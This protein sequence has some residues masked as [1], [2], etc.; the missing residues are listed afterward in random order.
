MECL[1]DGEASFWNPPI[2]YLDLP[3]EDGKEWNSVVTLFS[4]LDRGG[5]G[6]PEHHR[7]SVDAA[8]GTKTPAGTF[9]C[10]HLDDVPLLGESLGGDWYSPGIGL[11]KMDFGSTSQLELLA[12]SQDGWESLPGIGEVV[13]LNFGWE[14]GLSMLVEKRGYSERTSGERADTTAVS[15]NYRIEVGRLPSGMLIHTTDFDFDWA[16]GGGETEEEVGFRSA[17]M[18]LANLSPDYIVDDEGNFEALAGAQALRDSILTVLRELS[19][20]D[21]DFDPTVWQSV[22]EMISPETTEMFAAQEWTQLVGTWIGLEADIGHVYEYWDRAP[23]PVLPEI[24]VPMLVLVAATERCPCTERDF[25]NDC[26]KLVMTAHSDPEVSRQIMMTFFSQLPDSSVIPAFE[27]PTIRNSVALITEIE[28]MIPHSMETEQFVSVT[29]PDEQG[30]LQSG[31][32]LKRESFRF[33]YDR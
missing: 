3:L 21:E 31:R 14:P 5:E 12:W 24:E 19:S 4:S 1:E 29:Y 7:F 30:R 20:R 23:S 8:P 6:T 9:D 28:T 11:V 27:P 32:Q 22:E 15:L 13:A 16:T 17:L 33:I 18:R 26:V 2:L 25:R 10:L